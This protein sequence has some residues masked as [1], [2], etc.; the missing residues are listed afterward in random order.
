MELVEIFMTQP[1]RL[2]T[3]RL[4]GKIITLR[5]DIA[6]PNTLYTTV[7]LR[8]VDRRHE[9]CINTFQSTEKIA[10]FVINKFQS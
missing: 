7:T 3:G 8:Y 9:V 1:D 6:T 10:N 4:T 2:L 5:S